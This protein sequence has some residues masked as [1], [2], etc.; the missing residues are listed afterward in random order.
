M[1]QKKKQDDKQYKSRKQEHDKK[2]KYKDKKVTFKKGQ[3]GN[4][5]DSICRIHGGNRWKNCRLKPQ[6]TKHDPSA[7]QAYYAD[8]KEVKV[9]AE[10]LEEDPKAEDLLE[11]QGSRN[12]I[13]RRKIKKRKLPSRRAK[14]AM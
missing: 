13:K 8:T 5:G 10:A 1:E 3:G 9:E 14:E 6:N 4:G 11:D 7:L 2:K 12:T